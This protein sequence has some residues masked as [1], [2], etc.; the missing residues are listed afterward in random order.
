[1]DP[2]LADK[3][4]VTLGKKFKIS[5]A[6]EDAADI[7]CTEDHLKVCFP[8]IVSV[9]EVG[10]LAVFD[11]GKMTATVRE[12]HD[13]YNIIECTNIA[14]GK[15]SYTLK[16]RKGICVRNKPL[17]IDCITDHDHKSLAFARDMVG[18]D[19]VDTIMVS[20]FLNLQHIK[21]FVKIVREE[22]GYTGDL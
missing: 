20:Y 21:D 9:M 13:T 2:S 10:D 3:I 17:G 12:I 18:F 7:L 1:M 16:G 22:Y 4:V 6:S 15:T 8:Q 5:Y 11:D 14:G 19:F